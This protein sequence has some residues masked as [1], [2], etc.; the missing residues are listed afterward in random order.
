MVVAAVAVAVVEE[1]VVR[2]LA[3]S[4]IYLARARTFLQGSL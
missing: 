3:Y 4:P 2:N 1:I